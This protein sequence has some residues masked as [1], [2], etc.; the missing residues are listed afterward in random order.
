MTDKRQYGLYSVKENTQI[1]LKDISIDIEVKD[2][3]SI[4]IVTQIF[5]NDEKKSIEAVY[6]FPIE[7]SAAVCGFEITTGRKTIKGISEEREKAFEIYD[8]AI[9]KG[10][11]GFLL[12]QEL[13]DILNIS[14][15]NIKPKQKVTAKITYVSELPVF[16]NIIRLQIP[17]TVSPRYSPPNADPE[18]IDRISPPYRKDVPY[19]FSIKARILSKFVQ[20]INSPSHNIK[21]Q[22]EKEGRATWPQDPREFRRA[23]PTS[24]P[25][26][27]PSCVRINAALVKM[28][29]MLSKHE[30]AFMD[31]KP[32]RTCGAC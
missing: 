28:E 21:T 4:T 2:V 22:K 25:D 7:E 8:K 13:Q 1:S 5:Q 32:N 3:S 20:E 17:T 12:D 15:G 9:E 24:C 6:C 23:G 14:V 30:L 11:A 29:R 26:K 19:R 31:N 18:K 10:N 16:D 27:K